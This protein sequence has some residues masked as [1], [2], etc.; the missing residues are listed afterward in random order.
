MNEV[1]S[2]LRVATLDAARD[3]LTGKEREETLN[4]VEP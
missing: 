1:M 3:L 2:A 4:L